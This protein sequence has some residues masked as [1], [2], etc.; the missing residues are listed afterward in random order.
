[1][2]RLAHYADRIFCPR[3][4]ATIDQLATAAGCS[5]KTAR[6]RV[7]ALLVEGIVEWRW[8]PKDTR[9]AQYRRAQ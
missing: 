3:R 9:R 2:P 1:M 8:D 7:A 4:W 5:T 6:R